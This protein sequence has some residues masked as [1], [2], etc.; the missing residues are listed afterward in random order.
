MACAGLAY[1]GK[2]KPCQMPALPDVE[3]FRSVL[4][5]HGAGA[6][7]VEVVDAGAA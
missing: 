7:H 5:E 1:G 4:A 6:E 2:G 3:G